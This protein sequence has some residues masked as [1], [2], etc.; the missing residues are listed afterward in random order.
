MDTKTFMDQILQAGR[1]LATQGRD[2]TEQGLGIPEEGPERDAALSALGKGAVAG[3]VLALL[4]GTGSGRKLTGG[5]LKVG[6]LAALSGLA[7]QAYRKWQGGEVGEPGYTG[8]PVDRLSGPEAEQRSRVLLKAMLAAARS[9]GHI[10]ASERE[11]IHEGIHRLGLEGQIVQLIDSELGAPLD[12]AEIARSADSPEAA[13]EIYL[14]SLLVIVP[15]H[16]G[17]RRYLDDLAGHLK[18]A[19]SLVRELEAQARSSGE[20]V[21]G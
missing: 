21:S 18:L 12:P 14:A 19:P 2:V 6:G 1:K 5:V 7:Y 9:D 8:T 10:D 3:G 4:L 16:P 20:H 15:D 17:E 13:A 11:K